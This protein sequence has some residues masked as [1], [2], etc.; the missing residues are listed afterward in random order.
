MIVKKKVAF[1]NYHSASL[2]LPQLLKWTPKKNQKKQ[3]TKKTVDASIRFPLTPLIGT[4]P[5]DK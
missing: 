5:V 4:K 2:S 1:I 3:K